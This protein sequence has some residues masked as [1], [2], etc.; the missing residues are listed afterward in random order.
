M[1]LIISLTVPVD[2][3]IFFFNFLMIIFGLLLSFTMAGII[4]YLIQT[5]I[6]PEEKVYDEANKQ[7]NVV[8]DSN[9][10]PIRQFSLLVFSGIIMS[11]VYLIPIIL[12]PFDFLSNF[13]AY[14]VG[15]FTYIF[16]MPTFINVM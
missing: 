1:A 5:G 10:N 2:R 3:G 11:S 7:W 13:K 14:F 4:Y 12:R 16:M 6:Y 8:Y 9:G 15:L